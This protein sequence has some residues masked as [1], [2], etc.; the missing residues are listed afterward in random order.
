MGGMLSHPAALRLPCVVRRL[1][2]DGPAEDRHELLVGGPVLGRDGRS[3]FSEPVKG[4]MG[5]LGLVT[6][7]A[8][9]VPL[10]RQKGQVTAGTGVD[11]RLQLGKD[12]KL[13]LHARRFAGLLR[14]DV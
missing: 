11:R 6:P 10:R 4:A 8:H 5:Q 14:A 1:L 9:F 3:C 12:G 13:D 7:V 2:L